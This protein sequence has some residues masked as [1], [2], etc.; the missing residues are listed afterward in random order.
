MR[1]VFHVIS[2][3]GG[4]GVSRATRYIAERDKDPTREG[5]GARPLFNDERDDL[6]YRNAD[7]ILDPDGQPQKD[8]ILHLSVSFTEHDF[9]QLGKDEKER[10]Q[11]L[12]EVIREGMRGM[13][14]ELNV[15]R[16]TWVA[17][18]HRNTENPHTHIVIRNR[19]TERRGIVE[20]EIGRLRTSLLPHRQLV[21]GK[22]QT[23]PGRI[24]EKFVEALDRRLERDR[25]PSRAREAWE[26]TYQ[27]ATGRSSFE[28]TD[29]SSSAQ[30]NR[31]DKLT[32]QFKQARA[33]TL[34]N[35]ADHRATIGTWSPSAHLRSNDTD[36][37][38][39]LG[40]HLELSM[41]L[42]FAEVW[43]DRAVKHGDTCRFEVLDQSTNEERKISELDVHRRAAA[44]AQ[45]VSPMDQTAREH[46][47]ETDLSQHR[48]T[49]DELLQAR[50]T[51]IAAL[52]KDVGSL[53]GTVA[54]VEQSLIKRTDTPFATRVV[55]IISRESLSELQK[56]A[57]KLTL[58]EKVAE[59]EAVRI[60]L[61]REFGGPTRTN[62][63]AAV[64]SA[65]LTVAREDAKAKNARLDNFEAS[66]HLTPYEVH[67]E[68]WSLAAL[69]KQI[70][71]RAEDAKF[72]PDRAA[73]LDWRSLGRFN[74]STR[75]RQEAATE[76]EHLEFI[77]TEVVRQIEQ[78]RAP[79]KADHNVATELRNILEDPYTH[80]E[81]ARERIGQTMP[82]PR[83]ERYQINSLEA[84]AEVLR[85]S[86]LLREVH[87]WEKI[88]TR[89]EADINWQGRAVAREIMAGISVQETRDRLQHFLESKRL[90]SLNIGDHRTATLRDVEAKT[91]TDY[92]VR[93]I[94][95]REQRQYRQSI[96]T[97][98]REHH[99]RLVS[100]FEKSKDYYATARELAS[101]AKTA[102]PQFTDK[103]KINLEI[104]AE[105]Q[106][107]EMTRGQF[108]ELARGDVSD[109]EV[110]VSRER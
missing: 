14:D 91:L 23:V 108:L 49:L 79:L 82:E 3:G 94:E 58:P 76:V 13:A 26:E 70:A 9:E 74:Y 35:S 103:E 54:K 34:G 96:N 80:E 4:N 68:R 5:P 45:R 109:R 92:A 67:G 101:Q 12:R 40:R 102:E 65:Q 38:I 46:V 39:A 97:A 106:N 57:I 8:D 17:G 107:D 16:L 78:R 93:V 81:K 69:D 75:A 105:R 51:R 72:V 37:R 59:L 89:G 19:V 110:A 55:P 18:I 85:D 32:R 66:M 43:H 64:L 62:D 52:G 47:Y 83:Y 100:D 104:Y 90:A 29:A 71:R 95:S 44:R 28:Q 53:R 33:A 63:E 50:E 98:A 88:T 6:T 31:E 25:H 24:G 86:N 87:D 48:A 21:N 7:R 61:A 11:A 15:E 10:L 99:G 2:T 56:T 20:K 30:P 84:S 27:K 1:V 41:R 73:R 36:Y 22:E 42:A 77:R 60:N